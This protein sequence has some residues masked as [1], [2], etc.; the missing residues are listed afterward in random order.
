M[1]TKKRP[2]I[3]QIKQKIA[4][5]S[6]AHGYDPGVLLGFAEYINGGKFKPAELKIQELKQ[7]VVKAFG[8]KNYE[9]LKKNNNFNF[10][11]KSE[12][13]KLN[14]KS[15][16]KKIYREWV[17][18][19]DSE[20]NDIGHGCINGID[21][22]K[23]FRPWEVFGL[24]PQTATPEDIKKAFRQLAMEYHPDKGGN[25]QILERLKHMRDSLLAAF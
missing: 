17:A 18:I 14:L 2:N 15:S 19:P 7:A 25:R 10:Y 22:F 1:A 12:G 4:D 11:I 9:A 6:Q 5:L 20:K 3:N 13:L 23:N 16:W 8:C 21:I 24:N